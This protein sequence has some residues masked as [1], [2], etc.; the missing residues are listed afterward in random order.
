M[1]WIN[2]LY[3]EHQRRRW[4]RHDWQR[5]LTPSAIAEQKR[6]QGA[7]PAARHRAEQADA[8]GEAVFEQDLL[9]LRLQLK[10]LKLEYE[11]QRFE[12]KYSPDQPR[13]DQGRWVDGGQEG[14]TDT[15]D[16]ARA[17]DS[18]Q[19]NVAD[20]MSTGDPPEI[21]KDRPATSEQRTAVVKDVARWLGRFGG[22]LGKIAGAAYWLYQYDA[23]ITASLDPPKS[24]EE[25]QRAVATPRVGYEIHHI[26]EQTSAEQDGYQ[27]S[28][29]DGQENLVRIPT[30][31]H[32]EITG[33]YQTKNDRFDGL[34]PREYLRGKTWE[35][36]TEVGLGVLVD[37]E[38]LK[39]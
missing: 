10:R 18:E 8:V 39:P 20:D 30:L 15:V 13:D 6:A 27:R 33:W 17:T 3:E 14:G 7:K 5:F 25:L 4:L 34:A 23:Q 1:A 21:P 2:P 9:E 32:R 31:K 29:I 12:Q 24:L 28:L 38:V 26:V 16:D 36:R 22:T 35:E 19:A 37:H 11:L